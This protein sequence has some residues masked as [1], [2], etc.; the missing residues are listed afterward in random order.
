[1]YWYDVHHNALKNINIH[2]NTQ[3][4][5]IYL[6]FILLGFLIESKKFS[7][8]SQKSCV[9]IY[10]IFTNV[11]KPST[12]FTGAIHVEMLETPCF[13]LVNVLNPRSWATDGCRSQTSDER[14][15]PPCSRGWCPTVVWRCLC[16][17]W[18]APWST[19]TRSPFVWMSGNFYTDMSQ[20]RW[21]P[22]QPHMPGIVSVSCVEQRRL[23]TTGSTLDC[24][25]FFWADTRE[26]QRT[27]KTSLS[28][29]QT[30]SCMKTATF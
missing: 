5:Q 1:M 12:F 15:W 20:R 18:P 4:L 3:S 23:S 28:W 30:R 17:F 8:F 10:L 7:Y 24:A 6:E 27:S 13:F 11:C 19:C 14:P 21:R 16:V 22:C 26:R 9:V 29:V 2:E 25:T